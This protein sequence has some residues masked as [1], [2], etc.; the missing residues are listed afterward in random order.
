MSEER[1]TRTGASH[2]PSITRWSSSHMSS[3]HLGGSMMQGPLPALSRAPSFCCTPAPHSVPT[4][5]VQA[6]LQQGALGDLSQPPSF[7]H[8]HTALCIAAKGC[9]PVTSCSQAF[10]RSPGDSR[11][12][13]DSMPCWARLLSLGGPPCLLRLCRLPSAH[14]LPACQG[15]LCICFSLPRALSIPS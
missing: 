12:G 10:F 6:A 11:G 15:P 4:H 1:R 9:D 13:S 8:F 3:E 5:S 7:V 14:Q 2:G